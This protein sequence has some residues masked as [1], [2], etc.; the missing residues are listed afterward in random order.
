VTDEDPPLITVRRSTVIR[1][2]IVAAVLAALGVGFAIGLGA[3]SHSSPPPKES[4]TTTTVPLTTTTISSARQTLSPATTPPVVN[5]CSLPISQ[6]V[7]GSPYPTTCPGGGGIN[8]TAWRYIA[9]SYSNILGLGANA[10][11]QQVFQ[12]MCKSP[13]PG[14]QVTVAAQVAA[15]YYGW[16]FA[17]ALSNWYPGDPAYCSG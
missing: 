3:S 9:I 6:T 2:G 10:S 8:V 1:V 17:S 14:G 12:T 11:E 4:A 16:S 13:T 5:E 7:D 15:I